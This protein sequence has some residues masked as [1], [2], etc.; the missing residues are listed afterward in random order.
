MLVKLAS[1]FSET[2]SL[3]SSQTERKE[4]EENPS[5]YIYQILVLAQ[6]KKNHKKLRSK[7][8]HGACLEVK[9]YKKELTLNLIDTKG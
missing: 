4:I 5:L 2:F 7:F 6:K 3:Q 8:N 9:G 1:S